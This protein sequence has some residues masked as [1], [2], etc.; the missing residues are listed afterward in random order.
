MPILLKNDQ[1]TEYALDLVQGRIVAGELAIAAARRHL[2][3]MLHGSFRGLVWKPEA[4]ARAIGFF[5]ACLTVT[6]GAAE[7]NP[8]TL[9][10]WHAFVV[11]SLFGWHM[12]SG[13]LRFRRAWLETVD[14]WAEP[15]LH[16]QPVS[17]NRN[18]HVK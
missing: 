13:R 12:K 7:G 11:G 6:A 18:G 2:D 16:T 9:L 14:W 15:T 10:P 17:T 3:D 5:P 8:F 1:T 4:A